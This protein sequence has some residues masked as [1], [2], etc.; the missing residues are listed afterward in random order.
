MGTYRKFVNH[1]KKKKKKRTNY[2]SNIRMTCYHY[3]LKRTHIFQ[4]VISLINILSVGLAINVHNCQ[5]DLVCKL[6]LGSMYEQTNMD[7]ANTCLS[8]TNLNINTTINI[9]AS[10]LR[11][12]EHAS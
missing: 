9:Q 12:S 5:N 4:Q 1:K 11:K 7:Q 2:R 3:C 6:P 10:L 8:H